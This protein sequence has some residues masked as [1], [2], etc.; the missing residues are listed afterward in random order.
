MTSIPKIEAVFT[1]SKEYTTLEFQKAEVQPYENTVYINITRINHILTEGAISSVGGNPPLPYSKFDLS[2]SHTHAIQAEVI[3]A[4]DT[5]G[6][7][8][9]KLAAYKL[10]L[11][12]FEDGRIGVEVS[13]SRFLLS[14]KSK[15][16][17]LKWANTEI[18]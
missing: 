18:V 8:V 3:K 11:I 7:F 14:E 9:L 2:L 12:H 1:Q 6:A 10:V 5:N 17:L 16:V 15:S 13:G 4:L